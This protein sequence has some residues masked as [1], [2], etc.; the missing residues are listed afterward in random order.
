MTKDQRPEL[1]PRPMDSRAEGSAD[2][3]TNVTS[4][5]DG[6]D[7]RRNS[8]TSPNP[9]LI[10]PPYAFP[11]PFPVRGDSASNAST[12]VST[13]SNSVHDSPLRRAG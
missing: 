8:N 10:G 6:V 9:N 12:S 4:R 1:S 2:A 5:Q 3:I 7:S 11:F 13:N